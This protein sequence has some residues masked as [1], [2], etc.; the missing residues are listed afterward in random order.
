MSGV[1]GS[2]NQ[3]QDVYQAVY[4]N[5]KDKA[6]AITI[7]VLNKTNQTA[8]ITLAISVSGTNPSDAEFIEYDAELPP[9]GVLERMGILVNPG[10]YVVSKSSLRDVNIVVYG[11]ENGGDG[12]TPLSI[13][14]NTGINPTWITGS[15]ATVEAGSV[16]E[17]RFEADP[18][19]DLQSISSYTLQSGT[20]PDGVS[21]DSSGLLVGTVSTAGYVSPDPSTSATIRATDTGGAYTDRAFTIVR[22]FNDG[23]TQDRAATSAQAIYDLDATF[24][25]SG[26]SGWFWIKGTGSNAQARRMYCSMNGAGY[27]LWYY[28]RDPYSGSLAIDDPGTSGNVYSLTSNTQMFMYALPDAIADNVS[29]IYCN[30]SLDSN[31]T[32]P[33][34]NDFKY[35]IELKDAQILS[36]MKFEKSQNTGWG[37]RGSEVNVMNRSIGTHYRYG[38]QFRV[39]MFGHNWG[40]GNEVESLNFRNN[41]GSGSTEWTTS[42]HIWDRSGWGVIDASTPTNV[43]SGWGSNGTDNG[44]SWNRQDRVYCWCR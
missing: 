11:V 26:A 31:S 3:L 27:M 18:G 12:E 9:K 1:L 22:Q 19:E 41:D 28:Y 25:G 4:V 38:S 2:L 37:I 33:S 23:S 30:S 5:N 32:T 42:S 20:L 10:Q 8:R 43:N 24:Q 39:L 13:V 14:T 35:A 16:D 17:F 15:T 44:G 34:F 29:Y 36:W 40:G 7:N 6:S 21:L